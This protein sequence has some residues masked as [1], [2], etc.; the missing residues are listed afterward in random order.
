MAHAASVATLT[1][2]GNFCSTMIRFSHAPATPI[3]SLFSSFSFARWPIARHNQAETSGLSWYL[4]SARTVASHAPDS[5][6]RCLL[7]FRAHKQRIA[8]L[9]ASTTFGSSPWRLM[10]PITS[11]QT[12]EEGK[13]KLQSNNFFWQYISISLAYLRDRI[14][15]S[16]P[17][18]RMLCSLRYIYRDMPQP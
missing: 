3:A 16:S 5:P 15:C 7:L 9:A 10:A 13:E 2:V 14:L 17:S 11:S 12:P 8:S 4:I 18:I 1:M 6:R